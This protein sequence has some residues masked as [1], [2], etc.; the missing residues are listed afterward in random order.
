ME[1]QE[2]NNESKLDTVKGSTLSNQKSTKVSQSVSF[3]NKKK[4]KD[5]GLFT[6]FVGPVLLAF[7]LIVLIPFFTGIYYAFTDWN[8]VTGS[9]KWVGLDNFKYLFTEDKQFQT[10]FILTTKYTVVAIILTNLIGFGLALLVA[11]KLKA[12]NV[13]RTVFFMPNLIGGLILGFIWQFIFVKGFASIGELTGIPLFE[14]AWLGDA[15]T[16]FW[17]I[18]IVSVWQGA[19]YIMIIYIAA[20]QNVPQEL[21]EAARID[22]ANRFQVLR[23]ITMPLV[24]PAVTICLFLTTASSFKVFDANL[25]LTNGGPFKSTEMLALNIYTEAFV[26]NRY[27]IGEAKALIFFIVVAAITVLQVSISKKREVES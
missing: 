11:Q 14:L 16:A 17:G 10:S 15:K 8:G 3:L 25:S 27:G 26:N 12:K 18:V 13:L 9:V 20:L 6:L 21:I 7:I 1:V 19:G 22:G 2:M 24:A 5:A 4:W 23:H